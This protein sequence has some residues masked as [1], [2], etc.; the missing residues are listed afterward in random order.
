MIYTS[1]SEIKQ[2]VYDNYHAEDTELNSLFFD[3]EVANIPEKELLEAYA[4]LQM[5]INGDYVV[6][7]KPLQIKNDIVTGIEVPLI[8]E[9]TYEN[10]YSGNLKDF[11]EYFNQLEEKTGLCRVDI[12]CEHEN[13]QS[14]G[15]LLQF[16][17]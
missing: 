9:H 11:L 17:W 7:L 14:S 4:E 12:L 16:I 6:R 2:R 5:Q 1:I 8:P 15:E 13:G 10:L 3:F